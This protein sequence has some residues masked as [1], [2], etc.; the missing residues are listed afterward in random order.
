MM[1]Q[2]GYL[3]LRYSKES[4]LVTVYTSMGPLRAEVIRSKLEAAGIP[5]LLRYESA[6]LVIGI[7]VDGLGEVKVQ[8]PRELADEARS[9]IEPVRGGNEE[10]GDEEWGW[11]E[12]EW[13]VDEG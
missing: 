1:E 12:G 5:V 7:T 6:G 10:T 9:L 4:D 3:M 13:L 11:E 8:V 2:R